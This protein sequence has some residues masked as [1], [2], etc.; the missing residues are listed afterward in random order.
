MV[1]N[2]EFFVQRKNYILYNRL[3]RFENNI[4]I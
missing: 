3:T 1:E 2:N 4:K